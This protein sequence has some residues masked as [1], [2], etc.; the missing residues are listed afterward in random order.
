VLEV[1]DEDVCGSM[2]EMDVGNT[3]LS[4][5]YIHIIITVFLIYVC[6]TL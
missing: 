5:L 3:D 4:S 2:H 6:R 1:A